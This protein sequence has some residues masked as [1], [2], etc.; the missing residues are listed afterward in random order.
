VGRSWL[1]IHHLA[2][3]LFAF[4]WLHGL[5]TGTDSVSLRVLYALLAGTLIVLRCLSWS[6]RSAITTEG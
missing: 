6:W 5:L 1:S 2:L 4:A 3:T